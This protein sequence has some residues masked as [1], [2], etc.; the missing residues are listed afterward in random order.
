MQW[1]QT[2]FWGSI[3]LSQQPSER[4]RK[5]A[6]A[7]SNGMEGD[8]RAVWVPAGTGWHW[9]SAS[10]PSIA[11][12][13]GRSSICTPWHQVR[14]TMFPASRQHLETLLLP[15]THRDGQTDGKFPFSERLTKVSEPSP[16]SNVLERFVLFQ[17]SASREFYTSP[18]RWKD[19][20]FLKMEATPAVGE[21]SEQLCPWAPLPPWG[22][23]PFCSFRGCNTCVHPSNLAKWPRMHVAPVQ[24][25]IMV[26]PPLVQT[27]KAANTH[28]P[29]VP[30]RLKT[31]RCVPV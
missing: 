31:W 26:L 4:L 22:Q 8:R 20:T 1:W 5:R 30:T 14:N 11:V 18:W 21:A 16:L 19:M 3:F 2:F 7:L 24:A 12:V 10:S 6:K 29:P 23:G 27:E 9:Q 28:P 25:W 17:E 15:V 13:G